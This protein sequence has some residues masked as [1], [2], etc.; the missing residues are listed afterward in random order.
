MIRFACVYC[1]RKIWAKDRLAR[2][3][4]NCPACGHTIRVKPTSEP[5]PQTRETVRDAPAEALDWRGKSDREIARELRKHRPLTEQEE[6]RR[7][8]TQ[9]LS[10]FMPHY[11]SLTLFALSWAFLLLLL[12]GPNASPSRYPLGSRYTSGSRAPAPQGP[13]EPLTRVVWSV[14]EQFMVLPPLAG[15]GMVLSLV[16]VFHRKPKPEP[17][18]WLMLCFAVTVTAVTGMYAGHVWLTTTRGWLVVFPASNILSA[19]VPLLLFRA[20]LLD[21]EVILD[22]TARLS[23]VVVTLIATTTLLVT[24]LYLFRLHWAMAYSICVSYTMSLNHVITD[25]FGGGKIAK[26][27][28]E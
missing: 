26:E 18:K 5:E 22:T 24:C 15:I 11:D 6:R 10:P 25:V 14:G 13:N 9:T 7:A 19:A 28:A 17:V 2:S 27:V 4:V 3:Q 23:Q 1:G 8:I 16:G 20:G 12:L 21:T